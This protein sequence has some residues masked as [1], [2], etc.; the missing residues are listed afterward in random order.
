VFNEVR[1]DAGCLCR[2]QRDFAGIVRIDAQ[3]AD[4][5]AQRARCG[6]GAVSRSRQSIGVAFALFSRRLNIVQILRALLGSYQIIVCYL[7]GGRI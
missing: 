7:C 1:H 3:T 4:A 6:S 2:R 5:E